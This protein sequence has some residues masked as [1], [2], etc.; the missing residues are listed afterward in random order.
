MARR[1]VGGIS[2]RMNARAALALLA[3]LAGFLLYVGAVLA[4]ADHVLALHWAVQAAYFVAAGILWVFP[5]R[6]LMIWAV[7][8][9]RP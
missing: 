4:L 2:G 9:G 6:R 1:R 5:T 7:A 3:F 8:G